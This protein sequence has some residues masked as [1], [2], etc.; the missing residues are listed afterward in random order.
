MQGW[1]ETFGELKEQYVRRS[2]DRL[3]K[4]VETMTVLFKNPTDI[5]SV[6]QLARHFHWL[7][8]SGSMYGFPQIS[9]LGA[10]GEAHCEAVIHGREGLDIER[11]KGIMNE[12][13][14]QFAGPE[15]S[16]QTVNLGPPA[17]EG[18]GTDVLVIDEDQS[19]LL[20]M[21]RLVEEQGLQVRTARSMQQGFA[22]I[23]SQLPGGLI[24]EIPLP[25][26]DAYELVEQIRQMPGGEDPAIIIVSKQTGFLDKVRSIHCG[27]DA[28][29]EKPIDS[30]A[31][32]RRLKYLLD[33]KRLESP[34]ILSVEDDPDQAA[35]IR[36]FLE[37]AGYQVRTC[38]DPKQFESHLSSFQPDL[39]LL[40]VML[41][42]MTG[43]ELARYLRQDE[44]HATLPVMFLT[45]Q[46]HLEA[47]IEVA[48]SGGDDH[49][50]K[51]VPP[52]LLLSTVAARLERARFLKTLLHRDGQTN[53]LNHSS[54]MEH[55][56]KV[57]A[58]KKRREGLT[59]LI[60]LDIDYFKSINE[61]HG[62]P[63]G[64]KVLLALSILLRKRLRQSDVVGRVGGDEIAV[65]AEGLDQEEAL[66][67]ATRLISDF[68]GTSHSTPS[69][70][71][72][73]ATLSGGIAML[74]PKAMD[75]EKWVGSAY[76]AL[77]AA[78]QAG[79]NCAM[80]SEAQPSLR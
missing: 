61:R 9:A 1:Q 53:L 58:Q 50:V 62:Y 57:V 66:A 4:V 63:G 69:H 54:F 3:G 34:K 44:R 24:I 68:A 10:E 67:L 47:R 72:F 35:F 39:V 23:Q 51:P 15:A 79:R 71:G 21:T 65:I 40:D 25:D 43:Y 2:S 20:G 45:T 33:K 59:A 16:S 74:D 78:K 48:R 28:H 11:L 26:G 73:Y 13:A 37:S 5:E 36:A 6:K 17:R 75:V 41:P 52:A 64:D 76:S 18:L 27:A 77:Q 80:V 46:G 14:E 38:T 31:L 19:D 55:A 56:Q 42:G 49:L 22:E 29:F 32:V 30:K 60:V 12:L 70:A 7:A 8:G